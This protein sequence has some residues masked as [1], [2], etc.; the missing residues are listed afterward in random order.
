MHRFRKASGKTT[1][2]SERSS[3][4]RSGGVSKPLDKTSPDIRTKKGSVKN[5]TRVKRIKI[6]R[7]TV[8]KATAGKER[9]LGKGSFG[10][11]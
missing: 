4:K 5:S 6:Q 7:N 2:R 8:E 1:A 10:I 11:Y 9:G 3:A